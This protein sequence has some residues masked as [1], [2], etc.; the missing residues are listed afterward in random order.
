MDL[1]PLLLLG[2]MW[3]VVSAIRKA[4]TT[5]PTGK[6][7]P[8]PQRPPVTRSQLPGGRPPSARPGTSV[9]PRASSSP[10][11]VV[12]DPT[13]REGARLEQLLRQ[14]G[15]TL[16][17]AAG[18]VG[19]PADRA[20]PSA[21]EQ[22]EGASLEVAPEVQSLETDAARPSRQ[23]VD[24]DDD[25]EQ[26]VARRLQAAKAYGAPRTRADHRAFD[27]RIRQ[28]A[29]D[30]TAVAASR[31]RRLQQGVIWREI[32]GPPVSLREGDQER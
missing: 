32:L 9:S 12:L 30:K 8:D 22:E 3:L 1:G 15:R 27:E 16:E 24:Q 14:L 28:E 23:V 7:P 26:I 17:E 5:P 11:T 19:R 18:P 10:P 25:A 21:E 2:L 4:G 13:Q 6:R 31:A 29:A 20:L